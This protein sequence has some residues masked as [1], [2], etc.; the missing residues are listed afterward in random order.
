MTT[1][2]RVRVVKFT[3]IYSMSFP[4]INEIAYKFGNNRRKRTEAIN[5]EVKDINKKELQLESYGSYFETKEKFQRQID[6]AIRNGIIEPGEVIPAR[7]I[8]L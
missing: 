3:T 4:R 8:R 1:K 7:T 5:N 6:L 2:K